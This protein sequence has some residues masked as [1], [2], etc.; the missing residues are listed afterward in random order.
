MTEDTREVTAPKPTVEPMSRPGIGI[1]TLYLLVLSTASSYA[2]IKV[3]PPPVVGAAVPLTATSADTGNSRDTSDRSE[4]GVHQTATAVAMT[5]EPKDDG[6]AV[7]LFWGSVQ[8]D[9]A[10]RE[11]LRLLLVALLA[12]ALGAFVSS[13][14]SFAS[15]LG[16]RQLDR[17]W[18][19]WYLVRPPV[20]M[21]LALIAYFL[22]RAGLLSPG[23]NVSNVSPYGV[24]GIG[25]IMGMFVKEATDK[26]R[27]VATALFQSQENNRRAVPLTTASDKTGS[28]AT[29]GAT[30][31]GSPAAHRHDPGA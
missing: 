22:L 17:W 28:E 24:A 1:I 3:W 23:A 2:L 19:I 4:S 6:S 16:N 14:M 15:Y 27:D 9:F 25:G 13:A 26:M 29:S 12:G 31:V 18:A 11:E 21:V 7:V 5:E 30:G 20:G 8:L 10:G